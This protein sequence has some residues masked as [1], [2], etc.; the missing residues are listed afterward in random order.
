MRF[1]KRSS[2]HGP[3][4]VERP[5]RI[6]SPPLS[7]AA[8]AHDVPVRG[9]A[10]LACAVAERRHP[11]GRHRV[12]AGGRLAL[13]AAVRVIDRVHRRA[14]R[15]RPNALVTVAPGLADRDV[16]VVGVAARP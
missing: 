11:P 3:F 13:A 10:L 7:A 2:T 8:A 5:I 6:Y 9:F 1:I 12:T 4:F 16:L 14:A 15:L